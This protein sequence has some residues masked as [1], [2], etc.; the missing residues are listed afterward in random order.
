M[1]RKPFVIGHIL[2]LLMIGALAGCV[3]RDMNDLEHY[4]NE[5]KSRE[6]GE[7]EPLP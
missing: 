6:Q 3:S 7:I 2:S 1:S 5:V 4:V